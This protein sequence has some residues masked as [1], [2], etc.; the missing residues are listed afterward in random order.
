MSESFPVEPQSVFRMV[1]NAG[2]RQVHSV[3]G[4]M[5]FICRLDGCDWMSTERDTAAEVDVV[6]A[7][8]LEN[9]PLPTLRT[10]MGR[11]G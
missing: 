5:R 9:V 8:H 7:A 2:Q 3:T 1:P 11:A 6:A 10:S 4:K